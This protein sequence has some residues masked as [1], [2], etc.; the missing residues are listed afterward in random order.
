MYLAISHELYLKR[1]IVAGYDKVFTIGRYFRNEG[2]DRSH[3]PEFAMVET[4]AA[5]ENYEYNMNL[6]E[7]MFRYIAQNVFGKTE[8][9][10]RGHVID[11]GKPWRRASMSDLVKEKT[12]VD[13]RLIQSV[14]E[15]NQKLAGMGIHEPQP[16]V[17]E[18]LVKAF[19]AAPAFCSSLW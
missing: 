13:F 16:T 14:E 3:H 11:F 15:A 8:F 1:L 10:V 7:D 12:G 5:Y 18:A 19:E 6:I 2:I 4:M 17:G 9:N